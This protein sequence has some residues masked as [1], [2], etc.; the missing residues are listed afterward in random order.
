M[1]RRGTDAGRRSA[2][3][4]EAALWDQ[5]TEVV[6]A[7]G[8]TVHCQMASFMSRARVPQGVTFQ[9]LSLLFCPQPPGR[10]YPRMRWGAAR[11]ENQSL[12]LA[13]WTTLAPRGAKSVNLP[14]PRP[15]ESGGAAAVGSPERSQADA[16]PRRCPP[17]PALRTSAPGYGG[18]S[19]RAHT[20]THRHTNTHERTRTHTQV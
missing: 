9:W 19:P 14:R 5:V 8:C 18:G 3:P 11:P 15:H 17:S 12:I 1:G 6:A 16:P 10:A 20:Y 7:C 13:A 2:S 4:W